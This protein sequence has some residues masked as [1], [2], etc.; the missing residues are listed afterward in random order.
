M[1]SAFVR[2][3]PAEEDLLIA[4]LWEAGTSGVAEEPGGVRAF[5]E[6]ER[7]LH[8]AFRGLG[9]EPQQ[10]RR[11]SDTD[12]V[13][14]TQD[15]F[16]PLLIGERF[17]LAP[18]W[19]PAAPPGRLRLEINPGMA[20]GTGYHPCTQLCLEAM[21]RYVSP[22]STVLDV[23]C[24]SGIL[25]AAATLLRAKIAIGCDIDAAAIE[26]ARASV[27]EPMFVGSVDAIR[28][29]SVDVLIANISA[30]VTETLW[31]EFERCLAGGGTLI[32]S[33]FQVGELSPEWKYTELTTKDDWACIVVRS[34]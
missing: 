24:G 33:G 31:A 13:K 8:A 28:A 1:F 29:G 16:P 25:L 3:T 23:G 17:Y 18:P 5:F 22:Q 14:A 21:E 20:C 12:W 9:R 30:T 19:A 2:A 11:E 7:A 32:V 15:S 26:V 27:R 4:A 10:I 6:D 34:L